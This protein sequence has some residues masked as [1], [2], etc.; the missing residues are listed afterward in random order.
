MVLVLKLVSKGER[1]SRPAHPGALLLGLGATLYLVPYVLG[2]QVMTCT[3][4]TVRSSPKSSSS[5]R[6]TDVALPLCYLSAALVGILGLA[7][8]I[9]NLRAAT[10]GRPR[11]AEARRWQR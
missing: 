8:V 4:R 7:A 1:T 9:Y 6:N 5:N 11:A 10:C 3:A 2:V